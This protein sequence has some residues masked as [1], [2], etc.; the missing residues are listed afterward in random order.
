MSN[1]LKQY[2]FEAYK[3][4]RNFS[5]PKKYLRTAPIQID[6]QDDSDSIDDFC[7]IFCDVKKENV[8]SVELKGRFPITR[9]IEDLVE[10]YNGSSNPAAGKISVTLTLDQIDVLRD[11]SDKI[12]KTSFMGDLVNNPSWLPVSARTI[13]SLYR[14]VRIIKEYKK[15][16]QF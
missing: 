13:S 4:P 7:N 6:D 14:F 3:S 16:L 12:R 8:F 15:S 5:L 1:R 10:I 11:L 9:E 2:L